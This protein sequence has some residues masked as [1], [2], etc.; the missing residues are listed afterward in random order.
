MNEAQHNAVL[1]KQY[2]RIDDPIAAIAF[3]VDR[4]DDIE[5]M[6]FLR[7]WQC[8]NWVEL[9]CCWPEFLRGLELVR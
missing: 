9:E 1:K 7:S 2:P 6:D 5:S 4:N 3:V 8:G